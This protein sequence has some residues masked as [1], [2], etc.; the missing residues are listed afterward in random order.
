MGSRARTSG[1]RL[2]RVLRDPLDV[3]RLA[4]LVGA[5][6]TLVLGPRE[7]AVRLVLTFGVVLVPRALHVPRPFDLAFLLGMF[8][9]AWGNVFGAFN[10]IHGYDKVV[11][12]VLPAALSPLLYLMLV[13]FS[14]APD[15]AERQRMHQRAGTMLLTAAFGLA[16]GGGLYELYE[17]FANHVL[18]GHLYTSY[19]DTIGDL[20]DDLLGALLGGL[21]V[22]VWVARH[23]PTTHAG[24]PALRRGRAAGS[25]RIRRLRALLR[26]RARPPLSLPPVLVT[27]WTPL[28]RDLAD[29]AR[30][31]LLGGTLLAAAAGDWEH[32]ARFAV[33]FVVAVAVRRI[34]PPRLFDLA[35]MA[36]MTFQA[37]GHAL[38]GSATPGY[39][40]ITHAVVSLTLAPMLYLL[41]VRLRVLPELED[42]TRL[43]QRAAI[44]IVGFALGFCA[45]VLFE[46]YL[47]L[48]DH[49]FGTQ[50]GPPY[51]ALIGRLAVDAGG[52]LGGAALLVAWDSFGW[53]SRRRLAAIAA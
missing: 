32:S 40:T 14:L 9:Q 22:S 21:L 4:L 10:G 6:V 37:W 38:G 19:G 36:A 47:Y 41:V 39:R 18:G 48:V 52:A 16:F 30:L 25:A 20:G 1:R 50:L 42:E 27:D 24:A 11:H 8:F 13:R 26:E 12:F 15:F 44:A 51:S 46:L 7:Q 45:G 53:G 49:A 43:H 35:F 28:V 5:A 33:S 17:W 31:S 2:L 29:V 34:D 3:L 23:W